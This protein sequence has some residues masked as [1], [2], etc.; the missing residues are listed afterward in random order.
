MNNERQAFYEKL[1]GVDTLL[2]D[3]RIKALIERFPR[4]LV[5][6]GIRN[7]LERERQSIASQDPPPS[8]DFDEIIEA[9]VVWAE[10]SLSRSLKH[11]VNGTGIVLHTGLGRAP[12]ALSAQKALMDA[13]KSY[14]TLQIDQETGKRGDRYA[15]VE[16]LLIRITGA[17]AA[18]VVNNN[19]A[20]TLLI[21]NTLAG[22]KEVLVSRGELVEIGGSFRIPDVL[23]RSGAELVEVGT[24]NRTHLKDYT[25]AITSKTGLIL[26]VHQ[27]N[28]R[29]V[30]FTSL[31]PIR[32]LAELARSYGIPIVD[33]LGS[34]ALVDLSRW[35][36]TREPTVQESIA[37]GSDVVCFSGDK[38]LGG[39]QCGIIVGKKEY[40]DRMKKNQLTRALRCCKMTYAVLEETLRLYLDDATLPEK[41]PVLRLLTEPLE[42]IKKRCQ[43]LSKR[44]KK[45]TGEKAALEI[46][47]DE[48]EAGSGS[49]ATEL[50]PTWALAISVPGF[51]AE[52]L[53]K[54]L[55]MASPP[56]FGRIRADRFLLDSRTID[57]SDFVA[58]ESALSQT[59]HPVPHSDAP[60]KPNGIAES[61]LNE[62]KEISSE[63]PPPEGMM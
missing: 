61:I 17:E 63:N 51:S 16:K 7:F 43:L 58:I 49:L 24:T 10:D 41:L 42:D 57:R 55:R 1:P 36:L 4:A 39:P 38:L 23:R 60:G 33:D 25:Q 52:E 48:S 21:L 12:L 22:G 27:S 13:V 3:G 14:S 50:L 5:V 46:I 31:V 19:A 35:G 18:M 47:P 40:V 32:D 37:S 56:I 34:G 9:L 29:I 20:A 26:R 62:V 2:E 45:I 44:L 54:K 28:Y 8:I 15:H 30:G 11:A 6:E 59:I 53:A